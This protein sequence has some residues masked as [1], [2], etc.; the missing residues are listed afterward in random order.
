M[1]KMMLTILP[2]VLLV[3]LLAAAA[4]AVGQ[5]DPTDACRDLPLEAD[6]TSL[7]RAFKNGSYGS[8]RGYLEPKILGKPCSTES[9][10]RMMAKMGWKYRDSTDSLQPQLGPQV[11]SPLISFG[12]PSRLHWL[13][14]GYSAGAEFVL[15]QGSVI[16]ISSS[17]W[18]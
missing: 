18:T 12:Y 10:I 17:A 2:P 9:I 4:P 1:P 7:R 14:G 16:D 8:A 6:I 11:Y 15:H 13:T 5:S 3:V